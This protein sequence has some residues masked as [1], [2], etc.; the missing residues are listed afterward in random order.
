MMR[1]TSALFPDAPRALELRE[2]LA[3]HLSGGAGEPHAERPGDAEHE[4]MID[5]IA[6]HG[7][8]VTR[9]HHGALCRRESELAHVALLV[10]LEGGALLRRHETAAERAQTVGL[11]RKGHCEQV[12]AWRGVGKRALRV[13]HRTISTGLLS[14]PRPAIDTDTG[15]P[16]L[17]SSTF[18]TA[19]LPGVER[20]SAVP[21]ETTSPGMRV[22]NC[23]RNA[24]TSGTL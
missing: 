15:P 7:E 24:M 16:S 18:C 3:A 4:E 6:H 8:P 19:R 23:D 11:L 14:V 2:R 13:L 1:A 5:A 20:L 12:A 9:A 17:S 21:I 22:M 10:G